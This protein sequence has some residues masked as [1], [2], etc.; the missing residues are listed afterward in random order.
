MIDPLTFESTEEI[1]IQVAVLENELEDLQRGPLYPPPGYKY[2]YA[3]VNAMTDRIDRL[4]RVV[5]ARE[6]SSL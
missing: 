5:S 6:I 3:R 2:P 1:K 4:K